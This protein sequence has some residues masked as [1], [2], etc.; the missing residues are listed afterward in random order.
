MCENSYLSHFHFQ[1]TFLSHKVSE[2]F[3][4]KGLRM[5]E[6]V[7]STISNVALMSLEN[8]SGIT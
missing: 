1:Y 7:W 5:N 6:N 8:V 4:C 3:I 2:L